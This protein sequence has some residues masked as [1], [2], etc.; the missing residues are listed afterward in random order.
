MKAQIIY[1][2]PVAVTVDIEEDGTVI[3]VDS[4]RELG[5]LITYDETQHAIMTRE[6]GSE[7]ATRGDT[8][9]ALRMKAIV[10]RMEWP[11]R[12]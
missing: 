6:D 11:A 5:D 7:W 3:A 2:L 1:N 4:V 9:W 8:D 10:D 12:R